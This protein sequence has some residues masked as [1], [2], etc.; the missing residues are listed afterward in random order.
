MQD[1]S[2]RVPKYARSPC[3]VRDTVVVPTDLGHPRH[4][5]GEPAVWVSYAAELSGFVGCSGGRSSA[6]RTRTRSI[7]G[8]R[9][10]RPNRTH[11]ARSDKPLSPIPTHGW[12]P[13]T[14]ATASESG[15]PTGLLSQVAECCWRPLPV[16]Y[17]FT[18]SGIGQYA[19]RLAVAHARWTGVRW[20]DCVLA[21][22]Y[23]CRSMS[24]PCHQTMVMRCRRRR[25][26]LCGLCS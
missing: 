20:V 25:V 19:D 5:R 4:P 15:M 14:I 6:C 12:T 16:R 7:V 8:H 2:R 11:Q 3:Q 21:T 10:S 17:R 22:S 13:Y 1:S 18:T 9:I 23:V 26:V 24:A